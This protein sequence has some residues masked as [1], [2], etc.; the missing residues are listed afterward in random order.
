MLKTMKSELFGVHL[1]G[2]KHSLNIIIS[3]NITYCG[4]T[5]FLCCHLIGN[6]SSHQHTD[7]YS[8]LLSNNV[9]DQFESLRAFIYSLQPTLSGI[10]KVAFIRHNT[11]ES[12][13]QLVLS[14]G[15]AP[16]SAWIDTKD[17]EFATSEASDFVVTYVSQLNETSLIHHLCTRIWNCTTTHKTSSQWL[18]WWRGIWTEI[19]ETSS[20]PHNAN[21]GLGG[22][23]CCNFL[24]EHYK[25][26][27][28]PLIRG[29]LNNIDF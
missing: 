4:F 6:V 28:R 1:W 19:S 18:V 17:D 29:K 10:T 14:T 8:H 20:L 5:E 7:V 23:T 25:W 13:S 21:S 22:E 16:R 11:E 12:T 26:N 3:W 27:S 15:A 2:Q 9:R 24:E